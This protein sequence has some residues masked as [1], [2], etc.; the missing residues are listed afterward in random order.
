MSGQGAA[1]FPKEKLTRAISLRR[2]KGGLRVKP[3]QMKS[4]K[5]SQRSLIVM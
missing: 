5:C 4:E 3:L 1:L 2:K